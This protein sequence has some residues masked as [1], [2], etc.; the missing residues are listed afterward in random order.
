MRIFYRHKGAIE[1]IEDFIMIAAALALVAFLFMIIGSYWPSGEKGV[2]RGVEVAGKVAGI[3]ASKVD[4]NEVSRYLAENAADCFRKNRY[5][6]EPKSQSCMKMKIETPEAITEGNVTANL[7]CEDLPNN[8]CPGCGKCVSARTTEQD[9][10]FVNIT[11]KESWVEIR[12]DGGE[13]KIFIESFGCVDNLDCE[14]DSA[15]TRDTCLDKETT[16]S[17]CENMLDCSLPACTNEAGKQ[18]SSWC[19]LCKMPSEK[20]RCDDGIDNDC[21]G[22]SDTNDTECMPCL[23]ANKTEGESCNCDLECTT[24]L[25][26]ANGACCPKDEVWNGTECVTSV[27]SGNDSGGQPRDPAQAFDIVFVPLN[28]GATDA[29]FDRFKASSDAM[30][31][32]FL[33]T[34]P[35][36]DCSDGR[37]RVVAHYIQPKDCQT[38]C[39]NDVNGVCGTCHT[40]AMGCVRSSQFAHTWDKIVALTNTAFCSGVVGCVQDYNAPTGVSFSACGPLTPTHELGHQL[41]LCH[42]RC[43]G[44]EADACS[45]HCPNAADCSSGIRSCIMSYCNGRDRFCPAGYN[46]LKTNALSRWVQGC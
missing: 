19:S 44:R 46:H 27:S 45:A 33:R 9:K 41:G 6:L 36:K 39:G 16:Y 38:R 29:E 1:S 23:P 26:C 37:D 30:L 20:G 40:A 35:F 24:P 31:A 5:G 21:D 13:R 25:T 10:L 32:F 8:D 42:V 17:K 18:G 2:P 4:V 28:Y 3:N 15:C 43:T 34:S 11:R 7:K 14:D 22:T 12:Y